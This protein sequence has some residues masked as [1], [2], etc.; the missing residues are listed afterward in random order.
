MLKDNTTL[1]QGIVLYA[2]LHDSN[3]DAEDMSDAS[4]LSSI[5]SDESKDG[6][7]MATPF[8]QILPVAKNLFQQANRVLKSLEDETINF[9]QKKTVADFTDSECVSDFRFR[10]VDL[11]HL[12]NELWPRLS[13]F[14]GDDKNNLLLENRYHAP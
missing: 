1:F 11:Q 9:G 6:M 13:P 4:S 5:D 14:L 3:D 8:D 12:A 2:V 7:A 10:K